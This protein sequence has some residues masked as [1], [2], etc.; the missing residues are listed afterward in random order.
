MTCR[1]SQFFNQLPG[2][3]ICLLCP[4]LV[5]NKVNALNKPCLTIDITATSPGVLS[6]EITH[7]AGARPVEGQC[8]LCPHG[9]QDVRPLI[10]HLYNTVSITSD[11]L[12]CTV[13]ER[14]DT[15][16]VEFANNTKNK[17]LTSLGFHSF[18]FAYS[19]PSTQPRTL[20]DSL[21]CTKH[22]VSAQLS[23][24]VGE[25]VYSF[26]EQ[27]TELIKNGQ[28]IRNFNENG[29]S[30]LGQACKSMPFYLTN[31]GYG[32]FVEHRN[33]STSRLVSSADS[34]VSSAS[35]TRV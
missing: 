7:W 6:F 12:T 14:Q 26:G 18:G 11:A 17:V 1:L 21:D 20:A 2:K 34:D 9:R 29:G 32:V 10:S 35:R 3:T 16:V 33:Q 25:K 15:F 28:A 30:S 13:S 4:V 8:K 19:N 31:R 5:E 24:I 22:H 23:L 27:S